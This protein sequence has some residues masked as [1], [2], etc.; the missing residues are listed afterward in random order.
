MKSFTPYT[1]VSQCQMSVTNFACGHLQ[2]LQFKTHTHTHTHNAAIISTKVQL[3]ALSSGWSSG[4]FPNNVFPVQ[5]AQRSVCVALE[6]QEVNSAENLHAVIELPGTF[7][8][9]CFRRAR[10]MIPCSPPGWQWK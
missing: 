6:D 7:K 1:A 8:T 4:S 2:S 9:S 5:T 10:I 3:S